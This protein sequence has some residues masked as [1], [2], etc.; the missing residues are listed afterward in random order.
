MSYCDTHDW[1]NQRMEKRNSVSPTRRHDHLSQIVSQMEV[2]LKLLRNYLKTIY[3]SP[4]EQQHDHESIKYIGEA[5]EWVRTQ[6]RVSAT[7]LQRQYRIGYPTASLV[8]KSLVEM[9]VLEHSKRNFGFFVW[10][11][12]NKVVLRLV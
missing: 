7:A 1:Y 3:K 12:S 11:K 8:L 9:G 5:Q 4:G 2:S 6:K 10:K